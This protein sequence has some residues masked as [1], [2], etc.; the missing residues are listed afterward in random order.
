MVGVE[1]QPRSIKHESSTDLDCSPNRPPQPFTLKPSKAKGD[2]EED[3]PEPNTLEF[4]YTY[5][6][7]FEESGACV[8]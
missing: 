6:V 1:V 3:E 4:T 7:Y 2:D 8:A 5:G